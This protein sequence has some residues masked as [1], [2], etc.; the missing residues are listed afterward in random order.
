[1]NIWRLVDAA[2]A[3]R[4]AYIASAEHAAAALRAYAR[5]AGTE[6]TVSRA[7]AGATLR[8]YLVELATLYAPAT[9]ARHAA[10]L[11]GL[12]SYARERGYKVPDKVPV[13]RLPRPRA[14][15][16]VLTELEVASM[17]GVIGQTDATLGR[18]VQFLADTGC[19]VG[20][21][22]ALTWTNVDLPTS[23]VT[24]THTKNG[25][26]RTVPLTP[27]AM[28][29]LGSPSARRP[30]PVTSSQLNHAWRR[31]MVALNITD[32][33]FVPHAL[34]HT[35]GTKLAASGVSLPVVMRFLGHKDVQSAMRYQHAG[36]QDLQQAL[37]MVE[38][39][40]RLS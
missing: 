3:T 29:A 39:A 2:L 40:G 31:A 13:P 23:R 27:T 14:R 12:L 8:R 9:V 7:L 4:F 22:L 5:W 28:V 19:R 15:S 11:S 1:M 18:L 34:R 33:D 38:K 16:R 32:R 37:H 25:E 6:K 24:F 20:E 30:F 36:V 35:F 10:V 21:A 17:V 26:V